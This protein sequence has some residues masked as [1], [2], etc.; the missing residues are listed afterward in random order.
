MAT[1]GPPT[2]IPCQREAR[3]AQAGDLD[4]PRDA[5][6]LE[7][8]ER[9]LRDEPAQG[10]DA[11]ELLEGRDTGGRESALGRVERGE[12]RAQRGDLRKPVLGEDEEAS[13]GGASTDRDLTEPDEEREHL[14]HVAVGVPAGRGPGMDGPILE[15]AEGKRSLFP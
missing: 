11:P 8:R 1:A 10:V 2:E 13:S 12:R 6:A 14:R 3:T 15:R 9:V 4:A 5:F 7:A